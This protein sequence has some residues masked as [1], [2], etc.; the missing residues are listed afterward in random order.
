MTFTVPTWAANT[1]DSHPAWC[2]RTRCVQDRT[3]G[4]LR[5]VTHAGEEERIVV[6]N[7]ECVTTLR[8]C[9]TYD[10][11]PIH[12][13]GLSLA[14]LQIG[15]HGEVSPDDLEIFGRWLIARAGQYRRDD[16]I[17]SATLPPAAGAPT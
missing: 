3:G 15:T 1:V 13:Q 8:R 4:Y 9:D 12:Q 16:A 10:D 6:G 7:L 5:D 14:H 17:E 2:D 11:G